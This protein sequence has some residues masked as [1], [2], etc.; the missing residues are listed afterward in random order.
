MWLPTVFSGRGPHSFWG[1]EKPGEKYVEDLTPG[2]SKQSTV[3]LPSQS[4]GTDGLSP[5]RLH[6]A[7]LG[8]PWQSSGQD[9]RIPLQ[10]AQ[11]QFLVWELRSHKL[12]RVASGSGGQRGQGGVHIYLC[13]FFNMHVYLA[14]RKIPIF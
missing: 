1:K 9:S 14:A 13:K 11:V 4:E 5:W 3:A 6:K 12:H 10:G 8:I 7:S 2:F